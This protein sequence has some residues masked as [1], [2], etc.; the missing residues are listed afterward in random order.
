LLTDAL[1]LPLIERLYELSDID[2]DHAIAP[3]HPIPNAS[4]FRQA[5]AAIHGRLAAFEKVGA[6]F[7]GNGGDG[8]FCGLR[9]ALPFVDRFLEEGPRPQLT[10]TLRDLCDLT[11]ADR[12]TVLR[13]AWDR[14]RRIGEA[15]VPH[16]ERSGISPAALARLDN[17]QADHPWLAPPDALL[18][19]KRAHVAMLARSLRS[20]ELYPRSTAAV[21]IAPLMSQPIVELCLSIPTWMWIAEGRDRAVAR[22]A[23]ADLLPEAIVRRTHKGG[24]GGFEQ[25]IYRRHGD[26]LR[27]YIRHGSLVGADI[28]D[29]DYL[30][31][32][33]DPSWRGMARTDRLLAFAAAE[34]WVRWWQNM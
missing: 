19:G 9:S 4:Q 2:I 25:L 21:H 15:S 32:P 3:S 17:L 7:S 16:L 22:R 12:M 10:S 31:L 1:A 29:R 8:I 30:D 14:Y 28:I 34:S 18:P 20:L 26:A 33:D 27:A 13:H 23:F 5:I 6:H 11:G 24:P